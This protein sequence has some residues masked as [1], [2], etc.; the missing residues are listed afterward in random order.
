M[1]SKAAR[2]AVLLLTLLVVVFWATGRTR[3]RRD[4]T[5][6]Q[7]PVEVAVLVLEGATPLEPLALAGLE[8]SLE[9]LAGRLAEERRRHDPGATG[10]A[11]HV[12]L[13]GPLRPVHL[14]PVEPPREGLLAR[15]L[16][17]FEL[18]RA[19]RE[20]HAAARALAP[21]GAL[22]FDPRAYDVRV[23]LVAASGPTPFAEGI[24]EAGGEVA[25]VRTALDG[26]GL[27]AAT[28]VLHE[29]L[30]C[31]GATDKYDAA[32]HAVAPG[33]LVEPDLQPPYPQRLA[34]IM[35]GELPLAP[36]SGRLPVSAAEIGVGPATAA[37]VGWTA[38]R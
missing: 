15:P 35:V 38:A 23:H 25:V 36:G 37:E 2:V 14:P 24:G 5:T 19:G 17:A 8:R 20:A 22:P 31:L 6:W 16:F 29:A 1:P 12:E 30:H 4:R 27:L 26:D 28:A 7:R 34:E 9:H 32:G 13:I 18:W 33:G 11:F 3:T 10:P 21:P